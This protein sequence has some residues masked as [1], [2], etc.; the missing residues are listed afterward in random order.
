MYNLPL[1]RWAGHVHVPHAHD[2]NL[3]IQHVIRNGRFWAI[4][5][6]VVMTIS[7]M[8]LIIWISQTATGD[9]QPYS[10]MRPFYPIPPQIIP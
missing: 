5:G 2:V 3:R 8:A 9:L 4:L 6:L 1:K 10:P 7:L